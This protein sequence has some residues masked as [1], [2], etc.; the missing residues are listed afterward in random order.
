MA[1]AGKV[2]DLR[3]AERAA[4][5]THLL[6]VDA[7]GGTFK[8]GF[9]S[10]DETADLAYDI[11]AVDLKAALEGLYGITGDVT[12]VLDGTYTITYDADE[13]NPYLLVTGTTLTGGGT[14]AEIASTFYATPAKVGG[15]VDW[16]LNVDKT[17]IDASHM[18]T[19]G[20][21]SAF[22]QG[23]KNASISGTVR[24]IE[25]DPGQIIMVDNAYGDGEQLF[26]V[27][28]FND[29]VGANEWHAKCFVTNFN[30]SPPDED[31]SNVSFTV[32][33]DEIQEI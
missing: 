15:R 7:T 30:P 2:S 23:R 10:G 13:G 18:D 11:S 8:L 31:V 14:T 22:L 33:L 24:Y 3:L 25:T 9:H 17:E 6:T 16:N 20:G 12:V 32:R 29:S 19:V 4:V 1:V 27:F 26:A 28:K 21:W 5:Y